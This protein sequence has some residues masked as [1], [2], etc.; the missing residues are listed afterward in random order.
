MAR[1]AKNE[2]RPD[3]LLS[4]VEKFY[5][6]KEPVKRPKYSD[7]GAFARSIGYDI[8]NHI[9]Q[10]SPDVREYIDRMETTGEEELWMSVAVYDTL[11]TERFVIVNNSPS[12][13]KKALQERD[14]YYRQVTASAGKALE[15]NKVI[16]GI[17][18]GEQLLNVVCGGTLYQDL[19]TYHP[20]SIAHR[21]TTPNYLPSHD[22]KVV[23]GSPLHLLTNKTRISVNSTHHQGIDKLGKGL[24]AMAFATDGLTEGVYMPDKKFVLAIQWHPER[25]YRDHKEARLIF[26][27]FIR[28]A[29]SK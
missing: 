3:V 27:E 16:L 9:F 13:L 28:N 18:R 10:K 24:V 6:E 23:E 4:I 15:K 7:I 17:C 8:G 21:Q 22:V 11:D 2:H 19:P 25:M 26:E 29:G 14:N 5:A 1:K 20:S 12:K